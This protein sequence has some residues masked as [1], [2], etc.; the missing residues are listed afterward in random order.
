MKHQKE[1]EGYALIRSFIIL[2][3]TIGAF[4]CFAWWILDL[5]ST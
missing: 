2:T 1:N 5:L 3:F 4:W